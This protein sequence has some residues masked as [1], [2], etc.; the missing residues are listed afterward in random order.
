[1][2]FVQHCAQAVRLF[3]FDVP[4][5]FVLVAGREQDWEKVLDA[6]VGLWR[7]ERNPLLD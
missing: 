1:M 4:L 3:A 6:R 2:V 7:E 5:A